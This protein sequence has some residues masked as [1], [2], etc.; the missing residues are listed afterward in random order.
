[1]AGHRQGRHPPIAWTASIAG[2]RRDSMVFQGGFEPQVN[3][4]RHSAA[5]E[6]TQ[7]T[8]RTRKTT[9]RWIMKAEDGR[10]IKRSHKQRGVFFYVFGITLFPSREEIMRRPNIF[11]KLKARWKSRIIFLVTYKLIR[12]V[13]LK[14]Y[15][16]LLSGRLR[17]FS[18]SD[19]GSGAVMTNGDFQSWR[20]TAESFSLPSRGKTLL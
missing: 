3:F 5:G 4:F 15:F 10:V 6:K 13:R 11:H 14:D 18:L 8:V 9:A 7:G 16:S 17:A 19:G 1:M 2:S 20:E 12:K